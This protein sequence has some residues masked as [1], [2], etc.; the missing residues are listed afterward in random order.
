LD[1][2]SSGSAITRNSG[3]SKLNVYRR[4]EIDAEEVALVPT[5]PAEIL[6]R[7]FGS[8]VRHTFPK[9]KVFSYAAVSDVPAC[10]RFMATVRSINKYDLDKLSFEALC[11]KSQVNVLELM[12]AILIAAK[13]MSATESALKAVLSHPD[14]LQATVDA[15]KSGAPV[16]VQGN[17]LRD[18]DGALVRYPGDVAAQKLLHEAVGFLP[19]KKGGGIAI[20]FGFGRSPE[21]RDADSDADDAWD[22]AF[23]PLGAEIQAWGE[24][25]HKLLERGK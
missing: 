22:E 17:P 7:C 3:H 14:V 24:T 23:P 21:D 1:G 9:T 16:M 10:K 4:L 5:E 2:S 13:T 6:T 11:V 8:G 25:K 18:K 19:T 20:N 12:G 15:A